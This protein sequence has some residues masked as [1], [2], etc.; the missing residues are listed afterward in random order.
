[1]GF[2]GEL[3]SPKP[4]LCSESRLI[5]YSK[6]LDSDETLVESGRIRSECVQHRSLFDTNWNSSLDT[7]GF[8]GSAIYA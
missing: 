6:E 7:A 3:I 8:I 5:V 4:G 2:C 1:M